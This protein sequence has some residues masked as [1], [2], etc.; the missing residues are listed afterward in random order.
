MNEKE[1]RRYFNRYARYYEGGLPPDRR[2]QY[3]IVPP[4]G[5]HG[6]YA[7]DTAELWNRFWAAVQPTPAEVAALYDII[8]AKG[9]G[10]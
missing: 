1:A 10:G 5:G 7:E 4:M 9:Q 3:A 6:I 8:T 2:V